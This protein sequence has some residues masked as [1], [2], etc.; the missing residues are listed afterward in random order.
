MLVL[1]CFYGVH[2]WKEDLRVYV[3]DVLNLTVPVF[4]TA[5]FAAMHE[6]KP[7]LAVAEMATC[8]TPS[9]R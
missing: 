6:E 2:G 1:R 5:M 8:A 9:R 4:N 7:H 3:R